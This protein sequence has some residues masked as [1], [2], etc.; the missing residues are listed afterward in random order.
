MISNTPNAF[1]QASLKREKG[2]A[3]AME[4]LEKKAPHTH[5]GFVAS[6]HRQKVMHLNALKTMCRM[7]ESTSLWHQKFQSNLESI[8]FV[9]NPHD[10]CTVIRSANKKKHTM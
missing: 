3:R 1:V 5:K 8:G 2:K 6:E 10:A 9:F 7:L 4:P